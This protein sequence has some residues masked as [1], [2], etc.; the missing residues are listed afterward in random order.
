MQK[1]GKQKS[2]SN[3]Q[4]VE[5]VHLQFIHPTAATETVA[6]PYGGVNSLVT[7]PSRNDGKE[8]S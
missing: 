4:A 3:R 8:T 2:N 7:I 1:R 6:N 5:L